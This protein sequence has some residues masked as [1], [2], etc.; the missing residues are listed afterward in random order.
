MGHTDWV[1]T[2]EGKMRGQPT[3]RRNVTAA[4]VARGIPADRLSA[5]GIGNAPEAEAQEADHLVTFEVA[6]ANAPVTPTASTAAPVP[7]APREG[8]GQKPRDAEG[9]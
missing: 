1:G 9:S 6:R 8:S 5:A 4:L 2:G 3:P 7:P